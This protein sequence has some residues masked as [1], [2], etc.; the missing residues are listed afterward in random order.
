LAITTTALKGL[1]LKNIFR[2]HR[3]FVGYAAK[4]G[5]EI[6]EENTLAGLRTFRRLYLEEQRRYGSPQAGWSFF[7][8]IHR[9]LPRG[10]RLLLAKKEGECL[11]GLLTL[12]GH[13]TVF[14]RCSATSTI[15]A[16]KLHISKA[17]FWRAISE[18]VE[19]GMLNFN[20]GVSAR[21][22]PGL[23][24]FKEGWNGTTRSAFVYAYP[25]TS[26]VPHPGMYFDGF[27]LAK[28]VWRHLPMPLVDWLGHRVTRWIC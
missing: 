16:R 2:G 9:F 15:A 18:A 6:D 22:D 17:L 1:T 27:G 13:T 8:N 28:R 3:E 11:G 7:E 20:F 14:A 26:A 12:E 19:R 24:A 25:F 5:V 10:Y 23:I 4:R 21:S